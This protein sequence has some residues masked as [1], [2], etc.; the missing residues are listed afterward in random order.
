MDDFLC[1]SDNSDDDQDNGG[2]ESSRAHS[3]KNSAR[4]LN[5]QKSIKEVKFVDLTKDS[6]AYGFR[7]TTSV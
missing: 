1:I 2:M 7:P 3:I 5:K 6:E 4:T